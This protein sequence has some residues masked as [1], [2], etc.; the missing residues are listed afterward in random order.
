[1]TERREHD[2][3]GKV[4][5]NRIKK[6][7][8]VHVHSSAL[9]RSDETQ[10]QNQRLSVADDSFVQHVAVPAWVNSHAIRHAGAGTSGLRCTRFHF[11]G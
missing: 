11:T 6:K 9:Q 3:L 4:N 1:M 10:K 5:Q 8:Q 7:G 2:V